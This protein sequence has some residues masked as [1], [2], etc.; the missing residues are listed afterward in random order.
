MALFTA[1]RI[2]SEPMSSVARWYGPD[3]TALC[4][5]LEPGAA[6]VPHPRIAAG[7]YALKLTNGTPKSADY[8]RFYASKFGIGW[9][10]GMIE[11]CDVPGRTAIEFHVGNTI[12]DTMGCS[13]SGTTYLPPPSEGD[14]HY[15]V[16]GSRDAYEKTYP[17]LRDAVLA[18]DAQLQILDQEEK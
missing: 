11:I 7:T 18:G 2:A 16:A 12:A 10:K 1:K 8:A 9:H 17:I 3:G 13:L 6:R 15:E 14:E 5:C 4:F